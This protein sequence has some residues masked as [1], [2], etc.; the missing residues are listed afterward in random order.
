MGGF[1]ELKRGQKRR[2]VLHTQ[3]PRSHAEGE[4]FRKDL[5]R[6]IKKHKTRVL[7]YKKGKKKS[8]AKSR[9]KRT[10]RG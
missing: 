8:K 5:L 2:V 4:A 3:G 6:L 1:R 10:R 9:R 7:G